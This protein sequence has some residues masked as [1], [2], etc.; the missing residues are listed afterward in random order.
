MEEKW[1]LAID[2]H[3]PIGGNR[4]W[5]GSSQRQIKPSE[6]E[7]AFG[8]QTGATSTPAAAWP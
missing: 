2:D 1:S 5:V 6:L 8:W 7:A 3:H 4:W